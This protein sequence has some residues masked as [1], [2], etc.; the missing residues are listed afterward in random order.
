M[1]IKQTHMYI[2]TKFL[3]LTQLK[4]LLERL[5]RVIRETASRLLPKSRSSRLPAIDLPPPKLSQVVNLVKLQL[6]QGRAEQT[7]TL[8]KEEK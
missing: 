5:S 8:L 4:N 7:R 1:I 3:P 2:N 6:G